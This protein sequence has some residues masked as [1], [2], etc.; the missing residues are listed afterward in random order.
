MTARGRAM[1]LDC[2]PPAHAIDTASRRAARQATATQRDRFHPLPG[3]KSPQ[4]G[5]RIRLQSS[6]SS[7]FGHR[8][9]MQTPSPSQT[10]PLDRSDAVCIIGAGPSGLSAA[11]ALKAQGLD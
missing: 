5:A 11:R 10:F 7:R 2:Y 4:H 8:H 1:A 9:T 6:T 3:R